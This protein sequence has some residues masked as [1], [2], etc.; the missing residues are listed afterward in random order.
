[1]LSRGVVVCQCARDLR[2]CPRRQLCLCERRVA[3]GAAFPLG[4][5]EG[6]R[7][8]REG[9]IA[10]ERC[11]H[12]NKPRTVCHGVSGAVE[13]AGGVRN[14]RVGAVGVED[15]SWGATFEVMECASLRALSRRIFLCMCS[16][17]AAALSSVS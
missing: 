14:E 9:E 5:R 3:L 12:P 2:P 11:D 4:P 1:M 6:E 13:G 15:R 16:S 7:R 10:R 8:N 17:P